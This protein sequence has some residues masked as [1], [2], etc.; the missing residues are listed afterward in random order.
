MAKR[1][2][3]AYVPKQLLDEVNKLLNSGNAKSKSD[4]MRQ[5]AEN[6]KVGNEVRR[7]TK[8]FRK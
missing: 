5:I 3:I 1:G 8:I 6:H 2:G 7:L 4:A